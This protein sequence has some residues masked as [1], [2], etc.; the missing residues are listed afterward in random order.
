M[1]KQEYLAFVAVLE[2]ARGVIEAALSDLSGQNVGPANSSL[3]AALA[4]LEKAIM[5]YNEKANAHRT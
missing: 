2:D 3:K 4:R 1:D 5:A